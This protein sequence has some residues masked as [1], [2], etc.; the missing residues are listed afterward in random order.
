MDKNLLSRLRK[1]IEWKSAVKVLLPV[2]LL[3]W[4]WQR[5]FALIPL[6]CFVVVLAWGYF[7]ESQERKQFRVSFWFLVLATLLGVAMVASST[8]LSIAIVALFTVALSA[9]LSLFRF[10]FTNRSMAYGIFHLA[11]IFACFLIFF[12]SSLQWL[13]LLFIAAALTLLYMEFFTILGA[14]WKMRVVLMSVGT[15]FLLTEVALLTRALPLGVVNAAAFMAL[16]ALLVRDAIRAHF[17]GRLSLAS[18]LRGVAIFLFIS[19][20]I[21][22]LSMWRI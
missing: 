12:A 6:L 15:G 16:I 17:E 2:A 11:L 19:V 21:F 8:A 3:L 4:T 20:V 1:Q 5:E 7:T 18:V 13:S 9:E 22:G 14:P 10:L